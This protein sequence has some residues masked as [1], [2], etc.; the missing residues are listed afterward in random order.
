MTADCKA[1]FD[2]HGYCVC[3]GVYSPREVVALE[4]DFDRIIGQLMSTNE[5]INARW[6]G[7]EVERLGATNTVVLHTHNVQRYSSVWMQALLQ[8]AFLDIAESILGPDVI[9]HHTKLFQKPAEQG[10]PFPMHQDWSYFPSEKDSM[11]A[12]VIHVSAATDEMGCLRVYPGSHKNGRMTGSDGRGLS[13]ILLEDYPIERSMPLEAEPGD[14]V[15]F[16]Y[17]TI[18]GSLPNRSSAIRKTVLVQLHAGD[19]RIEEGNTHVNAGIALR[20][21]N[22]A[23]TRA[24]ANVD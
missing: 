12:A 5:N 3:R 20:G 10:A 13:K 23:M 8:P 15:F 24:R 4:R 1:F 6:S 2:E 14:V 22:H 18:H 21:W 11:V 16:H 7:V 9:L 19:D 17:F